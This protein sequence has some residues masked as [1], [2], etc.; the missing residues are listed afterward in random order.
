MSSTDDVFVDMVTAK[1][2]VDLPISQYEPRSMLKLPVHVV[3]RPKF[4]VVDY[5]NHFDSLQP[6]E[7]LKVMGRCGVEH[8][9]NITMRVGQP[10]Y[11]VLNRYATASKERLSTIG[12]M[13]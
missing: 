7:V 3:S 11:D 6:P 4:P 2:D 5:H 1:V 8:V 10:A 13:G 12:W 9:V